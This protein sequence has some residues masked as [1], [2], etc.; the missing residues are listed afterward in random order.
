MKRRSISQ[1]LERAKSTDARLSLVS[2]WSANWQGE[3][4]S[5]IKAMEQAIR[6]DDYHALCRTL[7]QLKTVTAKRF[8][9]LPRVL[10]K[11][12]IQHNDKD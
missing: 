11:L 6:D 1:R 5:L 4:E 8:E 12:I 10:E 9:A 2:D 3:Q 7:G